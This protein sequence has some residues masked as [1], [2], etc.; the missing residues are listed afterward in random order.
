MLTRTGVR[1]PLVFAGG[2]V[3]AEAERLVPGAGLEQ[4]VAEAIVAGQLWR[5]RRFGPNGW[6]VTLDDGVT[7]GVTR[8]LSPLGRR[9]AWYVVSVNNLSVLALSSEDSDGS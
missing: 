1:W 8:A 5:D 4:L 3:L 9:R 2:R 6:L 7:V